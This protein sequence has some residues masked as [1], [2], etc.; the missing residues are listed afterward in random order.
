[1]SFDFKFVF[2]SSTHSL[3]CFFYVLVGPS[4]R[5]TRNFRMGDEGTSTHLLL[6]H[7]KAENELEELQ[8]TTSGKSKQ[9]R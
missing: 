9:R 3:L 1:M 4:Y 8:L 2:S 7:G 5:N 6:D